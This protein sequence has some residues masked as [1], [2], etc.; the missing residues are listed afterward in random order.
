M[1][2]INKL[3]IEG[4]KSIWAETIELGQ[5]NVFLGTNGAGKSN[6]LEAIAMISASLEGG[7]DYE[8][9]ARRGARLSSPEIFRSAFKGKDRRSTFRLGISIADVEY[10]M[11]V[12]SVNTFSYL[13]ES[14]T[15]QKRKL[16]GRGANGASLFGASF[17]SKLDSKKSVFPFLQSLAPKDISD[18]DKQAGNLLGKVEKYSIYSPSTPILRGIAPDS[19]SKSPLGLYGGR[20]AEA[21]NE[22][23]LENTA[24]KDIQRFFRML[25]WFKMVGTTNDTSKDLISEHISLGRLKLTYQDNFMKT[26]FNELYAYDVSEGALFVL[27]VLVL[28]THKDA[29]P[30][31]ALDNVDNA[32]NPGL[33]KNL[34]GHIGQILKD[35]KDKQV[36]MTTHNPSTL[37]GLDIFDDS[38]RLFVVE[39]N[40]EGHTKFRR[41]AP[42]PGMTKADWENQYFGMKLSEIWLSG[43]IGGMPKGF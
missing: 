20:L 7:I 11:S 43:A 23:L 29:P 24:K 41:I 38:H 19:S 22:I 37:D 31:F 25:D 21:L 14:I 13:A 9:I 30:I 28:L 33:V 12:R 34:M 1:P 3:S 39:R 15:Q 5:I 10:S 18:L 32:L 26:N 6:L 40:D 42:P 4:F 2:I 36:F 17:T 27:F 35:N 16:A 8:R